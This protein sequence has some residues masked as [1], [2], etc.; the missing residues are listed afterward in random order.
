MHS[1]ALEDR[2]TKPLRCAVRMRQDADRTTDG[3]I[4]LTVSDA[5]TALGIS[6]EAVRARIK[7]GTLDTEREPDGTVYVRLDADRTR[8]DGDGTTDLTT[9]QA[10]I[11]RRL[12]NEVEFLRRELERKDHLLA[13]A[14]ERIPPALEP[15]ERRESPVTA[16]E[17]PAPDDVPPEQERRSWWRRF[18]ALM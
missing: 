16:S 4:R 11:M 3:T 9:A 7:R 15:P 2:G 10:L 8:K 13:A 12:E 14:L 1:L 5:A 6:A 18:F 17:S